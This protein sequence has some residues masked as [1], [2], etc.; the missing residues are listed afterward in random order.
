MKARSSVRRVGGAN[1]RKRHQG[2]KKTLEQRKS[3]KH[4]S[5]TTSIPDRKQQLKASNGGA[6]RKPKKR[7]KDFLR[8]RCTSSQEEVRK[9]KIE[10]DKHP[11]KN[12]AEKG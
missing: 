5:K 10:N 2:E 9:E 4:T 8:T 12:A 6:K 11:R 1:N 3:F 7:E